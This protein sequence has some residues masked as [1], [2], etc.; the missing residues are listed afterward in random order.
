[1]EK[2]DIVCFP[3]HRNTYELINY[4]RKLFIFAD[5]TFS[6]KTEVKH[7]NCFSNYTNKVNEHVLVSTSYAKYGVFSIILSMLMYL[8]KQLSCNGKWNK[9]GKHHKQASAIL[10][11]IG[12]IH[13]IA[14]LVNFSMAL[15]CTR[16]YSMHVVLEMRQRIFV[17]FYL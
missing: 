13:F 6:F 10:Q 5:F 7:I 1:M 8:I 12:T 14:F 17:Y 2:G 9:S 4:W 3:N 11:T 16:V 15:R